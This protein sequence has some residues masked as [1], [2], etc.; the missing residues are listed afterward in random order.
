MWIIIKITDNPV[1]GTGGLISEL[2]IA[3]EV[4][5]TAFIVITAVIIAKDRM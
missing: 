3:T 4:F 2:A 5:Q 1:T